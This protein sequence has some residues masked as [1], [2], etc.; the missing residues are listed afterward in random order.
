M[1]VQS[2]WQEHSLRLPQPCLDPVPVQCS[3]SCQTRGSAYPWRLRPLHSRLLPPIQAGTVRSSEWWWGVDVRGPAA[4]TPAAQKAVGYLLKFWNVCK[5]A[6]IMHK[7]IVPPAHVLP[8][9][10]HARGI[11]WGWVV[12]GLLT[13]YLGFCDYNNYKG[14]SHFRECPLLNVWYVHAWRRAQFCAYNIVL[15]YRVRCKCSSLFAV[16]LKRSVVKSSLQL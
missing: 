6:I 14:F 10:P 11:L 9:Q 1:T 13:V 2:I 7:H 16:L 12:Y 4:A 3:K 15:I 8:N 5:P